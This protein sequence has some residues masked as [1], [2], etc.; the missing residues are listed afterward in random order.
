MSQHHWIFCTHCVDFAVVCGTCGNNACNAGEGTLED[1]SPCPDCISAYALQDSGEGKPSLTE[2]QYRLAK[3]LC[4]VIHDLGPAFVWNHL[5]R[6]A[7]SAGTLANI[8]AFCYQAV[9]SLY[10]P[11]ECN[12]EDILVYAKKTLGHKGILTDLTVEESKMVEHFGDYV[13]ALGDPTYWGSKEGNS[14]IPMTRS[15]LHNECMKAYTALCNG[16]HDIAKTC[17]STVHQGL[18]AKGLLPS[19]ES[20]TKSNDADVLS[21]QQEAMMEKLTRYLSVIGNPT[22]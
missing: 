10:K 3:R 7:Q 17:F 22:E 5:E 6:D 13:A 2:D 21:P 8:E 19:T 18:V 14:R 12:P 1:G 11:I 9:E 4:G 15:H 16:Q 20:D